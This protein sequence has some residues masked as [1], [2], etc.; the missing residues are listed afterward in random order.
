M[1]EIGWNTGDFDPRATNMPIMARPWIS[2]LMLYLHSKLCWNRHLD[3][4]ATMNEYFELF[5][6][7][8]KAE[9]MEF[10]EFAETVWM[11]PEPRQITIA[12]GFLKQADVDRFF[13]ILGRAQAK[14][15]DS[16]YVAASRASW[17]RWNPSNC[18][19]KNSNAP[20]PTPNQD[21][22]GAAGGRWRPD[23][24]VL[25]GRRPKGLR[26]PASARHVDRGVAAPCGYPSG[27]PLDR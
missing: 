11:R 23:Q 12:G 22:Q 14:A 6:G 7:P 26:L 27:V 15:G 21:R 25:A 18:C 2:H 5:Y 20:A 4:Q 24:A 9:M 17:A 10:F 13:D 8:A 3:V 1:V 16:I 19:L